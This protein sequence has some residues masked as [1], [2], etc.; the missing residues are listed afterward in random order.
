MIENINSC[1]QK[2]KRL[3]KN[4][5]CQSVVQLGI[6]QGCYR[7][8]VSSLNELRSS[9]SY[10]DCVMVAGDC[11]VPVHQLVLAASGNSFLLEL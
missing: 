3:F 1:A 7:S 10:S 8:I 6:K 9:H 2:R 11:R 5:E 4:M